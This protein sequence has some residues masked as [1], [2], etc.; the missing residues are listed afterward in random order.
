ME[1]KNLEQ[2]SEFAKLLEKD[3]TNIPQ[4]GEVV[5]GTVVTASKSE[6]KLDIDGILMGV[7]R[8]PELY[9]EVE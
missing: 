4:V 1:D 9:N 5:K 6:V 3:Q 7:V 2:L 8:G